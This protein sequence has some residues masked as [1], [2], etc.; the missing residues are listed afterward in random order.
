MSANVGPENELGSEDVGSKERSWKPG[1][2]I[3]I[4]IEKD[5]TEISLTVVSESDA[6]SDGG[7]G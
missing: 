4:A 5:L 3:P 6:W 1:W 7:S 2:C